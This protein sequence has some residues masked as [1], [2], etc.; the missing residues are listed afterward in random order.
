MRKMLTEL[1]FIAGE[2]R[3]VEGPRCL[4]LNQ[5]GES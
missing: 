2:S 1:E 4:A 5:A 3:H